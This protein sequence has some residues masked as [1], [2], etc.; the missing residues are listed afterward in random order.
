[1][2]LKELRLLRQRRKDRLIEIFA[3]AMSAFRDYCDDYDLMETRLRF[4]NTHVV[5]QTK[6]TDVY[7]FHILST[8]HRPIYKISMPI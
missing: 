2:L 3:I 1:M 7:V 5:P 6:A 4:T 8:V